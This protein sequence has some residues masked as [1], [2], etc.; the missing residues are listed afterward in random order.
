MRSVLVAFSAGVDSAFLLKAASL[1]LPKDRILAVTACSDTYPK[2]ELASA[3]VIAGALGVRHKIITTR[4]LNNKK[5]SSNP[6]N[7]CY[8]CKKELFGS[9]NK[10]AKAERIGFVIDASNLSDKNDFRPGDKAKEE[11][12]VRSPLQE[13]GLSK[14]EIRRLS[15]KI[16]LATWDKPALACLASRIPY[17]SKISKPL[18]RR[19]GKAEAFLKGLGFKQVRLR[20]YGRLCRIEVNKG[21]IPR[22]ISKRAGISKRLK[23]LGYDY[24]TV[25]LEGYR[26]GSMNAPLLY[27]G[28]LSAR[29]CRRKPAA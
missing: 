18:L 11:E 8:F 26:A 16:G 10:I 22:L 21:D 2:E 28:D 25:D 24:I 29:H 12:G 7:R 6:S 5:F 13:A 20:H 17:G 9:L 19:I 14:N 3:K 15:K 4:E 27:A 1:A 23:C